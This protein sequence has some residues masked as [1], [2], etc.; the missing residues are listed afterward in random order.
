ME[1]KKLTK[2]EFAEKYGYDPRTRT[3]VKAPSTGAVGGSTASTGSTTNAKELLAQIRGGNTTTTVS[4]SVSGN[5]AQD[6]LAQI[7]S[8][9]PTSDSGYKPG[10]VLQAL[11]KGYDLDYSGGFL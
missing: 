4:E 8:T 5:G 3:S 2:Q 6:M 7:R 9:S 10:K 1:S 11:K